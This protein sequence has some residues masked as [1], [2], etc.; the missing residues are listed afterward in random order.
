MH[1]DNF[2][3]TIDSTVGVKFTNRGRE[4]IKH[5]WNVKRD[6]LKIHVAVEIKRKRILSLNVTSSE[7]VYDD[8][9]LSKL[10]EDIT[11]KQ[12]KQVEITISDGSYDSNRNFQFLSF[13]GIDQQSK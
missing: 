12:N 8:K 13:K 2:V 9:I 3:I 5:K 7:Q 6:Y 4:W 1:P 11:I 10:V